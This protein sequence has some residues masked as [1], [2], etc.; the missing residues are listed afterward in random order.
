MNLSPANTRPARPW[1]G[2]TLIELLVVIAVIAILAALLLPAL[3]GAKAT[4]RRIQCTS[5]LRQLTVIWM[6][7]PGDND[8]RLAL[9]GMPDSVP[10]GTKLWASGWFYN[11]TDTTNLARL[12]DPTQSSFAPYL[13][14]AAIYRCPSDT[15]SVRIGN[16]N[17]PKVRSYDMNCFLGWPQNLPDYALDS[18]LG[19]NTAS[20]RF[21][22]KYSEL[23]MA[24]PSGLY[25]FQ[26]VHPNSICW[27]YFGLYMLEDSF[28]NFPAS[29]HNY[30]GMLTYAD[31]HTERHRWQDARTVRAFSSDYHAHKEMSPGNADIYW[32]RTRA[33]V[34]K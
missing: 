13:K 11:L 19:G 10:T 22:T 2:F 15:G 7:Y 34:R 1:R 8:D 30:A 23:A 12:L 33:T 5:Q 4:A 27:P 32:L 20:Y 14:T 6:L 16:L 17:Y 24:K 26:D 28:F 21:F 25:V 31:G 3:K 9:N 18:R 29:Q